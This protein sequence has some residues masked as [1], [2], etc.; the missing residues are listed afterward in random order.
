MESFLLVVLLI[1]ALARWMHTRSRLEELSQR[2][3]ALSS[4]VAQTHPPVPVE[5]PQPAP[6]PEPTVIRPV[7][8]PE[9]VIPTPQ[10]APPPRPAPVVLAPPPP[11]PKPEPKP[12]PV[13]TPRRTYADW[14]AL[15][16][17]NLL[18]KAGIFLLVIGIALVLGYEFTQSGP[19]VRVAMSIAVSLVMLVTGALL[20]NRP[21]YRTFA[22]GLLGGGWAALYFTTYATQAID[23]A[24]II[25]NPMLGG[26]LLLAVAVGMIVHSLRY[27]S[28]TVTGLAYFIAFVTLAISQVTPLAVVAVIP[29]AASLLYIANRFAWRHFAVFGLIATYAICA[30]R[31]D[32]GTPLWQAQALFA[33]YWILFEAFDL[34]RPHV[35]L[36]PLNAVGFLG[37]SLVKWHSD[38]PDRLWQF[39]AAAAAAYLV[40][41]V[42]RARKGLWHP[43]V[44]LTAAL[45]AVAIFLKLDQQWVALALIL[46]AE[47]FYFAGVLLAQPYLRYLAGGLFAIELSH[48]TVKTLP[49]T[50]ARTWTPVAAFN[51][52]VF[53]ANRAIRKTD[54]FYGFAAA[55]LMA[56]I[57]GF[58]A[59]HGDRGLAWMLLAIIPFLIGWRWRLPDLRLQAYGLAV[60]GPIGMA[61]S[62]PEPR[63]SVAIGA[64]LT[65]AGA[66]CATR[67]NPDRFVPDEQIGLRS[68]A[69]LFFTGLAAALVW[70]MV[71]RE[72]LGLGWMALAVVILELG[73]R[74][75][76][77][78]LLRQA[79]FIALLG[80]V[81]VLEQNLVHI[82]NT[83]P[84]QQRVIPTVAALL[85]Y[86]MAARGRKLEGGRVLDIASV[87]A[88]G[89]L[90]TGLWAI[91]PPVAVGPAWAVV[92][93]I[94]VEFDF[95]V[96]KL[97][98][99]AVS[100]AAF[101]RLF[102]ANFDETQ[103]WM[104][105]LTVVPVLL[106]HYYLWSR[107]HKRFYLYAG[108]ILAATLCRFETDRAFTATGW[109]VLIVV[110]LYAGK[111]WKLRDLE[112]QSYALAGM[113]FARCWATNFYSPAGLASPILIG[114]TVIACLYVAQLLS[115]LETQ[116]RIYFSLLAS[117]LLAVLLYY[118][119]SGSMLTVAWGIE[120]IVLLCAGFPLRDR[121][122]RLSGMALFLSCILK[123]FLWDLRHLETMPR[124]LSFIALG[125]IL[126]A[127]SW[128][129]TRF[130][131]VLVGQALPPV[132][133]ES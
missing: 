93:L 58:E 92:A 97:Q 5:R 65:F 61:V 39:L 31:P 10:P 60:I 122:L 73:I 32:M 120:G 55:A 96:L 123:L 51:V 88:T 94:L 115:D 113:A 81:V 59:P 47:L 15:V 23:A 36:L 86:A 43:P 85:A 76:P 124:I 68:T 75:L 116:G 63:L 18:N 44:T 20:E 118:Q 87:A 28:Q 67:S 90:L 71:P 21:G 14:E 109:A 74:N 106:S 30:S 46:E 40:G 98:A 41:A 62:W 56:L 132:H 101:A 52:A 70:L 2:I 102:F 45:A 72:F 50:T 105:A 127:V 91:L 16:G 128:I 7:P 130:K 77:P 53:Y 99:H 33:I 103:R 95:P 37:L 9:R 119:V 79:Y 112:W 80:A 49:E 57:A 64:A 22:Q 69:S 110:Y 126:L 107:T 8:P 13:T 38:A 42:L 4:F 83:G 3:D 111:R 11:A 82:H 121:V 48:L 6:P 89:F 129:Y 131:D 19:A 100:I 26:I 108:A 84:W 78:E 24:K 34:L 133:S 29:L 25:D 104:T 35:A 1:V 114:A 66:L 17:G 117:T 27:R 125:L 12:E 54:I